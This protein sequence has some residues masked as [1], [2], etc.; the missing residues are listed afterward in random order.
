MGW[1]SHRYKKYI[2]RPAKVIYEAVVDAG[3]NVSVSDQG[4]GAGVGGVEVPV[5][6]WK[7]DPPKEKSSTPS[8][9]VTHHPQVVP[10]LAPDQEPIL[11]NPTLDYRRST[12]ES[13]IALVLLPTSSGRGIIG[14]Y[15]ALA[16]AGQLQAKA[17]TPMI[18]Q[19]F[20]DAEVAIQN[21][22]DNNAASGVIITD[23][24]MRRKIEQEV[25]FAYERSI[26]IMDL[27]DH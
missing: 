2:V 25:D 1:I 7:G 8:V 16:I 24:E 22:I 4:I 10:K 26:R 17:R 14:I 6:E 23:V 18:R 9:T 12:I 20:F 21:Y 27:T 3:V 13:A 19:Y 15:N 11:F 5:Y